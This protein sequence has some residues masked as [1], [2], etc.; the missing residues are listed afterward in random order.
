MRAILTMACPL[1]LVPLVSLADD[2]TFTDAVSGG[3][4]GLSFR[5]RYEFVD[6]TGFDDNAHASTLRTRL[7]YETAA[8]HGTTFFIE[9]DNVSEILADDF[10]N[11]VTSDP[12]RLKY[13]VVAD[14]E[15]TEINQA[16]IQHQFSDH[17]GMK[18]GRQR[19]LLDNQRF[20]GGVGWRQ[21]EQTYDGIS[22]TTR[23]M[24]QGE[25]FYA[26]IY[27]VNRIF[28]DEVSAGDHRQDTHLLN[29]SWPLSDSF[30][31]GGYFY[32]IDNED[33]PAFSTRTFGLQ[34]D[35]DYDLDGIGLGWHLEW[36][37]QSDNA[38]NPVSYDANYW[39]ING[40]AKLTA[41]TLKAGLEIL[42][43]DDSQ[44]GAA[45]R[46]PLATLHAFNGWA[47]QFLTT[48]AAGLEDIWLGASGGLGNYQWQLFWHDFS[49]ESGSQDYG[50]EL[51]VALSRKFSDHWSLLLKG[52][53]FEADDA[54]FRDTTKL[55]L[56]ATASF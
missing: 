34:M 38:N 12:D 42:E 56:M 44:T 39:A 26:Y 23:P 37:R 29:L 8:W 22:F 52:A 15:G 27:N 24:G 35:S 20:V 10:N 7:N 43:G 1:L 6:Q 32:D 46:T 50:Q 53:R 45:F 17:T 19:I 47:D 9:A 31:A 41:V 16:W 25:L 21:N 11:A 33:A 3:D 49:A 51:D 13:P 36:A 48:P 18:L 54:A 14:P 28:G 5:Y 2:T 30:K 4:V 40:S 55:W